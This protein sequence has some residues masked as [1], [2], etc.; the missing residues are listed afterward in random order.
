MGL[1]RVGEE[2]IRRIQADLQK[3]LGPDDGASLSYIASVLR[4]AGTR[5]DYQDRFTDPLMEEPYA[6]RLQGRLQFRDLP[7]TEASLRS[8]DAIYREYRAISDREGASLVR[9]L[10]LKGK[11]RAASMGAN[12]R[13]SPQK[14]LEKQEIAR[15]FHVWL[16]TADLFFDWLELRKQSEEFQRLFSNN[17]QGATAL[18]NS[19][20]G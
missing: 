9:S 6:S 11:Q 19:E 13:I 4:E 14:R 5:V 18:G 3:R 20:R 8:L 10:V 15:W 2:A 12:T 1:E 16:E 7:A 17:H